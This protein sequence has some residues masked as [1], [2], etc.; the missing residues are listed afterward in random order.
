ME[1][2]DFM[3]SLAPL[4]DGDDTVTIEMRNASGATVDFQDVQASGDMFELLKPRDRSVGV[5]FGYFISA[6]HPLL[7]DT[8]KGRGI[9]VGIHFRQD[10]PSHHWLV[11]VRRDRE[12]RI[13]HSSESMMNFTQD[14]LTVG[15]GQRYAIGPAF[16]PPWHFTW[17]LGVVGGL[18]EVAQTVRTL[19]PNE[20]GN[21]TVQR[22]KTRRT[23]R[24]YGLAGR[25]ALLIPGTDNVW[26]PLEVG[27]EQ[28]VVGS[29]D[30]NEGR[31]FTQFYQSIGLIFSF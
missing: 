9:S 21:T 27:C 26:F 6:H 17:S 24:D 7:A 1:S 5:A 29:A 15:Y 3:Q 13:G 31:S 10:F 22:E 30:S 18:S 11:Q 23:S 16:V 12:S 14:T 4:A 2:A 25:A 20:E 19:L 28:L 8:L